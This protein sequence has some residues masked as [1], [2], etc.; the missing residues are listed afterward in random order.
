MELPKRDMSTQRLLTRF[1]YSFWC[2][3]HFEY[4]KKP[5]VLFRLVSFQNRP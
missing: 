3:F 1:F 4:L 5:R 2:V